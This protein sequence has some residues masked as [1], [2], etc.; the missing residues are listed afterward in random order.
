MADLTVSKRETPPNR[1]E[2]TQAQ[3]YRYAE[4]LNDLMSQ[5]DILLQQFRT[6]ETVHRSMVDEQ[7]LLSTHRPAEAAMGQAKVAGGNATHRVEPLDAGNDQA[8]NMESAL[9]QAI[10][11]EELHLVYQPQVSA[12]GGGMSGVEALLRWN[13][14]IFGQVSPEIF[15]PI[16]ERSGLIIAIGQWA[17]HV[18]CQQLA[19]WRQAGLDNLRLAINI[20]PRQLRDAQFSAQ[21]LVALSDSRLP[22]SALELEITESELMLYPE[23]TLQVLDTLR[24]L[25][26]TIAIDDFGTGYS[27]LAR[28]RSLPVDRIKVDRAFVRDLDGD[29]NAQAISTC[30]VALARVMKLEVI[31]EGVET[32]SQLRH[33]IDQGCHTIQGFLFARPMPPEQ[34]KEWNSANFV[35][36]DSAA[37]SDQR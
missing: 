9:R 4:D 27:S 35:Q 21:V 29:A 19:C 24:T 32:P 26:V 5:Y 34:L 13:S 8:L 12:T 33:L 17:M 16:A 18:A 10:A 22:G 31:A 30:I 6:L 37:P 20:A 15:I 23:S 28:L 3:L 7:N 14:P 25:G 11:N 2:E 36:T 1:P